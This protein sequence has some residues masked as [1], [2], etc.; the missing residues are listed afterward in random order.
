MVYKWYFSCQL[1][2]FSMPPT[3]HL[4]GEPETTIDLGLITL[5]GTITYPLPRQFWRWFSFYQGGICYSFQQGNRSK[6]RRFASKGSLT[7]KFCLK[8]WIFWWSV[9]WRRPLAKLVVAKPSGQ[10]TLLGTC[11]GG[12]TCVSKRES[13]GWRWFLETD[14]PMWLWVAIEGS[15]QVKNMDSTSSFGGQPTDVNCYLYIRF[16]ELI[17]HT[18]P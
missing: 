7:A 1:G 8:I 16:G 11:G 15:F 14:K 9:R 2:E 17:V 4:L 10:G 18:F 13:C 3:S 6:N 12:T 5:Q